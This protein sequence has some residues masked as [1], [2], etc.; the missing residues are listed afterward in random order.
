MQA[1]MQYLRSTLL[2]ERG[3]CSGALLPCLLQVSSVLVCISVLLFFNHPHLI[4]A[5]LHEYNV[6]AILE[7]SNNRNRAHAVMIIYIH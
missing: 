4:A 6:D 7:V 2:Q 1:L 5:M 3:A